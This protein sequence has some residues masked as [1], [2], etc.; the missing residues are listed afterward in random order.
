MVNRVAVIRVPASAEVPPATIPA[1]EWEQM[2]S[3]VTALSHN[4]FDP[5]TYGAVRDDPGAASAN[6]VAIQAAADNAAAADGVLV[7]RGTYHINAEVR[8]FSHVAGASGRLV[9]NDDTL[10]VALL[11]GN[12]TPGQRLWHKYLELPE[13]DQA[14]KGGLGW[15][16][17]DTGVEISNAQHCQVTIPWVRNFSRALLISAYGS[18][19][20]YNNY[21]LG[22][23]ENQRIGLEL[24]NGDAVGWVNSNNFFGGSC[25]IN[26]GE[27]TN[28]PG[29]R[30]IKLSQSG[31]R[32]PNNNTFI[33]V[34]IE[35]N[36]PEYHLEVQG[37]YNRFLMCRWEATTPKALFTGVDA[38]YNIIDGGYGAQN[39]VITQ[40][41]GA[42]GNDRWDAQRMHLLGGS[43]TRPTLIVE[44]QSS[45]ANPALVVMDAAAGHS[46]DPMSAYR[47]A[48]AGN[49][50]S[51]KQ[52][53]D[54]HPR[55]QVEPATHRINLGP[56]NAAPDMYL[57][58]YGAIGVQTDKKLLA[59]DGLGTGGYTAGAPS[60]TPKGTIPIYDAN[61]T[62]LGRIPVY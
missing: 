56:G 45:G 21:Y 34:G 23:M 32:E 7:I 15:S 44:N 54:T 2:R 60:G 47:V 26:G 31:D 11:V 12:R 8:F 16:G 43:A 1:P 33:G 48:I 57:R 51:F 49:T 14:G 35:G 52:A 62:L 27:G 28:I 3:D 50:T 10:P 19:N 53:A 41:G 25:N 55:I 5:Q 37:P 42:H 40:S 22:L 20:V 9:V 58:R 29:V 13:V 61:G 39:I 18:G 6:V 30:H 17:L 46:A 24:V 4:T 38:L 59:T 36:A